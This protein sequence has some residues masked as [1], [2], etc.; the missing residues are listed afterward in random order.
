MSTFE[1]A[2]LNVGRAV[3]PLDDAVMADFM[4]WLDEINALA[5]RSP[6]F[7]W[8]L[9]GD[10]G[11]NTDLKVGDDP[12][13]IV[14]L[15]VWTSIDALYEFTYRSAHT[16]VFKRRL[17]WFERLGR[18]NTVLWWLPAGTI[19]TATEALARLEALTTRGPTR[20]AFTFKERFLA[21][22]AVAG[23]AVARS[24]VTPRAS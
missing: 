7:V 20:E 10:S 3:A 5:E 6:G 4:G 16:S 24:P 11:N 23:S 17:E 9:K 12:L 1:V 13:F 19:P 8:R 15:S 14:N 2:Q 18:P 21:P 22:D